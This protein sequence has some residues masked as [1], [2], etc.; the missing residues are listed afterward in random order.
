MATYFDISYESTG[1]EGCSDDETLLRDLFEEF[2]RHRHEGAELQFNP[3][4]EHSIRPFYHHH[5]LECAVQQIPDA[6]CNC[7]R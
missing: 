4:P 6:T 1:S 5:D 2:L 3:C 7:V